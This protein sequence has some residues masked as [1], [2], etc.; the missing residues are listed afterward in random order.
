MDGYFTKDKF[1]I[2][3][4]CESIRESGK[5]KMPW[6]K[7]ESVLATDGLARIV[8]FTFSPPLLDTIL[9]HPAEF[10]K[11]FAAAF[12]YGYVGSSNGGRNGIVKLRKEDRWMQG[13]V[14]N[15]IRNGA[16]L[17]SK[18]YGITQYEGVKI[19]VHRKSGLRTVGVRDPSNNKIIF[20]TR[21]HYV[22]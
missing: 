1:S 3:S 20:F 19:V 5:R 10:E 16:E 18:I 4:Y 14:N 8:Y 2:D 6:C 12:K 22:P 13:Y 21:M 11:D 15:F 17:L 7:T 9:K